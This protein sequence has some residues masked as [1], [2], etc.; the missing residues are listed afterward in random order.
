MTLEHRAA[1][2][3]KATLEVA[4]SEAELE[5][6]SLP[7]QPADV[8]AVA[9]GDER[10]AAFGGGEGDHRVGWRWSTWSWVMKACSGVSIDGTAPP[11]PKRQ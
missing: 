10:L 7:R 11:W 4:Q 2:V 1:S 5:A 3:R 9:L 6:G 8:G